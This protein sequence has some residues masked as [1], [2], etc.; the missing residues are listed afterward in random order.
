[1]QGTGMLA[2]PRSS[3]TASS[4]T[5]NAAEVACWVPEACG[6]GDARD[7]LAGCVYKY[8]VHSRATASEV[9]QQ[10]EN[11]QSQQ[12]GVVWHARRATTSGNCD[13]EAHKGIRGERCPSAPNKAV[14][15]MVTFSNCAPPKPTTMNIQHLHRHDHQHTAPC[16]ATG[17]VAA[18]TGLSSFH[19]LTFGGLGATQLSSCCDATDR[20]AA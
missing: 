10:T 13:Y 15:G 9:T 19:T 17:C 18:S 5:R 2:P 6:H 20:R 3:W 1:M 8:P 12:C 4:V 11:H 14:S 7:C 16:R